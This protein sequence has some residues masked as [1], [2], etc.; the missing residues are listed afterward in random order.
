MQE[1]AAESGIHFTH[2]GPTLDPKLSH[3]M[4]L[5]ASMGAV[6][7]IVDYDSDGRDDIFVVNSGEGSQRSLYHNLGNG[8][9]EDVI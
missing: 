4:P 7:S 9:F 5:I 6:V 2:Q 3:I 1:V 8:K